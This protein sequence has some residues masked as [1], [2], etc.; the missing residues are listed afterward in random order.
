M[1]SGLAIEDDL[2]WAS[3]I[4]AAVLAVGSSTARAAPI[5]VLELD[6][7]VQPASLRYLERGLR[8]AA[9]HD[10]ALVVIELD[11]PGGLLTSLR[12][13][14]SAI[15]A[16]PTP[17]AVYVT[18]SG[19]RAAS[20]GF[21]LLLA[22]DVAAMAPGTNT[23][24]ARPIS[25]GQQPDG[26][27]VIDEKATEDAAALARALAVQRGRSA[28]WA[29]Q[30]IRDARAYSASEALEYGLIDTVVTSRE[31]LV[32]ELDG[33]SV[34]RAD[35]TAA[36]LALDDAEIL[37][38]E[39]TF[40]ERVLSVLADPQIAYLLLMLGALGLFLEVMTP[41][42][43]V[44]GILGGLS[45]LV[46]FYGLS[47]LPVS[48]VGALLIVAGLGLV[49]A[50]VFFAT[51]GVLAI[52]G[53]AAF[54][55][56]SLMLVDSPVPDLQIGPEVVIPTTIILVA[57]VLLLI[58]RVIRAR[59]GRPQSGLDAMAGEIGE[60]VNEVAPD[61]PGTAFVHGEYWTATATQPLAAGT[62]VRIEAIE[63][64][65]LRVAPVPRTQGEP[66]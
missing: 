44:P 51:Y 25:I 12:T 41:G 36:R 26:D 21:F 50:E 60:L 52:G 56:G 46:G 53:I 22:A 29:E 24:A 16:S 45:L 65:R 58:P 39:H 15:L 40:A 42:L 31:N 57:L 13:M 66:P 62:R 32:H 37:V 55:I 11:T 35:G 27:E 20:A 17:V 48:W 43:F 2:M 3:W 4:F 47:M 5:V 30:A 10:A 14:V 63:G 64:S 59:R 28:D 7:S 18:P 49:I 6:D 38:L 23:G 8:H 1:R 34:T 61:H 54:T 19:A 9:D 33:T